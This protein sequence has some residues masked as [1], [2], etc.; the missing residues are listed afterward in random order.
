MAVK[1]GQRFD[2][3]CLVSQGRSLRFYLLILEADLIRQK[4]SLFL[5]PKAGVRKKESSLFSFWDLEAI[6]W[7]ENSLATPLLNPKAGVWK[8]DS[9]LFPCWD[10]VA[11]KW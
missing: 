8:Q 6:H 2:Q 9:I 4:D 3:L 10:L 5:H 7:Q 11:T 1:F